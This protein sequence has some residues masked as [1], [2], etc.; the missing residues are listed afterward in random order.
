M[1]S[2]K[3]VSW[4][5][6]DRSPKIISRLTARRRAELD[7]HPDAAPDIIELLSSCSAPGGIIFR[8]YRAFDKIPRTDEKEE[9]T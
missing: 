5:N 9:R 4:A 1:I 8:T 2:E 3:D 6:A 7:K